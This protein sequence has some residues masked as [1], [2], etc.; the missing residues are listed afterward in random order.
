MKHYMKKIISRILSIV[1]VFSL[2]P[3]VGFDTYSYAANIKT[4]EQAIDVTSDITINYNT[5][6]DDGEVKVKWG[7]ELF[8]KKVVLNALSSTLSINTTSAYNPDLALVA[9]ALNAAAYDGNAGNGY[10]I[11]KAYRDLGFAE[12]NIYL[13]LQ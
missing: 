1:M 8:E 6:N 9:A 5:D 11:E 13:L 3:L 2:I 12:E 4:Q 10:Y 7:P